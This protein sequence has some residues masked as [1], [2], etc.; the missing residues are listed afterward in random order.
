MYDFLVPYGR[1]TVEV[2]KGAVLAYL[3]E[4][5]SYL[6]A[7][8]GAV[9]ETATLFAA[10]ENLLR[11]LPIAWMWL[12]RTMLANGVPVEMISQTAKCPN[13]CKARKEKKG[14][15]LDWAA[16]ALRLADDLIERTSAEGFSLFA[17]RR[18]CELLRTHKSECRLF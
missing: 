11:N 6:S 7:L 15:R 4:P 9:S 18:G 8:G 12:M 14:M 10:V 1:K 17:G 3:E 16:A 5:N 2:L 13:S